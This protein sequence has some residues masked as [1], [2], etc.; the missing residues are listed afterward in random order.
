M[1]TKYSFETTPTQ[2]Y[3]WKEST[4]HRRH[5]RGEEGSVDP[6]DGSCSGSLTYS[7]A[8]SSI[9]SAAGESTDSS[10]ADIMKVLDG[11]GKDIAMYLQQQQ[12]SGRILRDGQSVAESLAYSTDAES[13]TMTLKSEGESTAL[14]GFDLVSTITG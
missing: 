12:Q 3:E 8:A 4:G 2:T 5:R 10:F 11:D 13:K 6:T 14:H 1:P 9:H 7:S